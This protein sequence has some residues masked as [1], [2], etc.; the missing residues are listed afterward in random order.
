M[1]PKINKNKWENS[2]GAHDEIRDPTLSNM[3][4]Q[5]NLQKRLRGDYWLP[6]GQ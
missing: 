3:I 1:F 2:L 5:K 4:I 6:M